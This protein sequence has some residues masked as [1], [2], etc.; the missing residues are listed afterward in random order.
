M[1]LEGFGLFFINLIDNYDENHSRFHVS[2]ITFLKKHLI[3]IGN[4]VSNELE[5]IY[6]QI[7]LPYQYS[8]L[9]VGPQFWGRDHGG[10]VGW[11]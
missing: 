3:L 5:C 6:R 8:I 1:I 10:G 4:G 7:A 11:G 9:I 2:I